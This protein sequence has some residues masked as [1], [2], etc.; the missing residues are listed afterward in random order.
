MTEQF[1]F[2]ATMREKVGKGASR[3]A[4]RQNLVPATIYG[5]SK[6]PTSVCLLPVEVMSQL[7]KKT[8][9]NNI[10]KVDIAG[11]SQEVLIRDIQLHPVSDK[12]L[13]VDMLR[14]GAKTVA[15]MEIPVVFLNQDKSPGLK[16]GGSLNVLLY[17]LEIAG[18]PKKA[19]KQIDIDLGNATAGT[20][21]K[22]EDIALPEGIKT[23]YPKGTPIASLTAAA[24]AEEEGL[25]AKK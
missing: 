10:Y 20:V 3:D 18:N 2:S 6:E 23:Y 12:P 24:A 16:F 14:V 1:T 19:P 22:I 4:R 5:D 7:T 15:R 9:Y 17:Y 11:K 25:S 13:H 21:I 8:L